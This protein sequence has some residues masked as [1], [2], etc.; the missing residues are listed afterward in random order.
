MNKHTSIAL[1]LSAVVLS[2]C[3]SKKFQ[4]ITAPPAQSKIRFFNFGVNAPGVNFY[5]NT[6]KMTAISST[7][8]V[9]STLGV[10]YGAGGVSST[11]YYSAIVPG[12]Y[13]FAGTIAAATD[14]DLA[15]SKVTASLDAGKAY[16][17]YMSGFYDAVA[18]NVEG[19]VVLDDYP[20]AIDF[21]QAYVR[22]VNAISNSNPMILYA[23]NQTTTTE[24]AVGT[25]IT[26]KNAGAFVPMAAGVYDLSARLSGQ[27]TNAFPTRTGVSFVAGRVYT[28]T[29]LGDITVQSTTLTNRARL[30]NTLN[31]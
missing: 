6:T 20:A 2:G 7:S 10:A 26:Y 13:T 11:G 30:D 12:S 16:S 31:R 18:K 5:A 14:K 28:V 3:G 29:S 4:D 23:K 17:F 8:G 25:A 24:S 19:F 27:T 9:E 1:L 15:V 21:T 22:F